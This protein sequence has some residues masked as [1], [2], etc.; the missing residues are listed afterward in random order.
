MNSSPELNELATALAKAQAVMTGALKDSANPFFKSKYADLESVWAACRKALTDNGLSVVQLGGI[1]ERGGEV[2][3]YLATRLLH[4]SGQWIEG[5]FLIRAKD[6]SPQAEGSGIT[7]ARRYGLAAMVGVY[8]TDDDAEAAQGRHSAPEKPDA[9]AQASAIMGRPH[10]PMPEGVD[11]VPIETIAPY[12]SAF[13]AALAK[14][15]DEA[16]FKVHNDLN[17]EG[18]ETY[19]AV[20]KQMGAPERSAVKDAVSRAKGVAG[21]F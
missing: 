7:Y 17:A 21:K 14:R 1:V 6:D 18:Q 15:N 4:S 19:A 2:I 3:P 11:E 13:R 9:R 12:L 16:I 5:A 10:T 8:Q 20:W